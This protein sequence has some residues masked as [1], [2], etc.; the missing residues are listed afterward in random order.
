MILPVVRGCHRLKHPLLDFADDEEELCLLLILLLPQEPSMLGRGIL[1]HPI[2]AVKTNYFNIFKILMHRNSYILVQQKIR[3]HNT[4]EL[5][6]SGGVGRETGKGEG[7]KG[8][9]LKGFYPFLNV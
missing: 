8:Q 9:F 6:P 2:P 7:T 5:C 3:H 1:C 4:N